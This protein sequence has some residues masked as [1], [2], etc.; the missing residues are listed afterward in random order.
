MS[1]ILRS[2]AAA[3]ITHSL[4]RFGETD[5]KGMRISEYNN[6][7][8]TG[9][10]LATAKLVTLGVKLPKDLSKGTVVCPT[11]IRIP[12]ANGSDGRARFGLHVSTT[13][14]PADAT[15]DERTV[16][17]ANMQEVYTATEQLNQVHGFQSGV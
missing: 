7:N 2:D 1:I 6:L 9:V 11:T 4:Q 5:D 8:A 16:I 17:R 12:L 15:P 10:T 3:T 13:Y 14:V